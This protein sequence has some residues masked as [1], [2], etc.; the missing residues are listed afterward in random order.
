VDRIVSPD[1]LEAYGKYI[2]GM[3]TFAK[4]PINTTPTHEVFH[5]YFDIFVPQKKQ[6]EII[7]LV[8][9][10]YGLTTD[11]QAEER[12]ADNFAEHVI[13]IEGNTKEDTSL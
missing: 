1:G 9:Q 11:I 4:D 3:I 10:K 6:R 8:K 2:N 12:L 7:E 5:A 13:A